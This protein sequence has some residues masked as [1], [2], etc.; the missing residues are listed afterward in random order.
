MYRY[1]GRKEAKHRQS[2][3]VVGWHTRGGVIGGRGSL[4]WT[5]VVAVD[6]G[7]VVDVVVT[8]DVGVLYPYKW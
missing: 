6:V 3:N 8:V 2:Q 7:V 5:G 1:K 4:L